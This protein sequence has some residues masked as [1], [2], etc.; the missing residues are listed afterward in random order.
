MPSPSV[1]H[2]FQDDKLSVRLFQ[3]KD[4]L[5]LELHDRVAGKKWGPAPLLALEIHD[6]GVRR[7]EWHDR[8]Q[9]EAVE[10]IDR[11]AHVVVRDTGR[12]VVA[13]LWLMVRDGELVVRFPPGEA[14]NNDPGY[15]KLVAVDVLPALARV[16]GETSRLL[17][18]V[19]GAAICRPANKPNLADRWLIY[20]EQPRWEIA[21]MLPIAAA[22]D[23]QG[24]LMLLATE[25]AAETECRVATDGQ[26]A[27]QIGFAFTVQRTW[28]DP[29]ETANREIRIIPIPPKN[30]PVH[31]V[32]KRLRRHTMDDLGKPTLKQRAEESPEVAYQ[33]RSMTIKLFHG[34]QNF[35][36]CIADTQGL[37]PS[38]FLSTMTF[39]EA[40]DCLR[41]LHALGVPKLYTQSV[42]WNVRGHDGLYPTRFPVDSRLGGEDGMREMFRV[43]TELGYHPNVHDNYQMNVRTSPDW[44]PEYIIQDIHGEPLM[45]G[46]WA[47]GFEYGSWPAALPHER[48]GGNFERIEAMGA[49]GMTYCDYWVTPLEVNYHPRHLGT[50]TAHMRGINRVFDEARRVFGSV[51]TEFGT[52]PGCVACDAIATSMPMGYDNACKRRHEWPVGQMLDEYA[53]VWA[54]ALH[55][56]VLHQAMGGPNWRNA[57]YSIAWGQVPRDEFGVRFIHYGGVHVF[58]DARAHGLKALHDLCVDRFGHLFAEE[59]VHCTMSAD[60]QQVETKFADG[61][62]VAADF[63]SLELTVNRKRIERPEM[64][65]TESK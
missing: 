19:N 11:G 2:Q 31:F 55:G 12:G 64:L 13:A 54:L 51:S 16:S 25:T 52:L 20:L 57:M 65:P 5:L 34:I 26:G 22:W 29:I 21:S 33:L 40:A 36:P 62:E 37:P 56:L 17:L 24:G 46:R 42:G 44:N 53:P 15:Y 18:P 6:N 32:S 63:K 14:Y 43:A 9:V 47:G 28:V 7:N 23:E 58:N 49:H 48:V 39:A 61:T 27:G 4:Q 10:E 60:R 3:D 30:D 38:H 35:G 45:H 8:Y 59:M 41:K 50:R 1:R